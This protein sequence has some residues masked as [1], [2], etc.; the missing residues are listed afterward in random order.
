[1]QNLD[2]AI[3]ISIQCIRP[4]FLP[5]TL[6][7]W[8]LIDF[9]FWPPFI[10]DFSFILCV[11]WAVTKTMFSCLNSVKL[12]HKNGHHTGIS[13]LKFS[14]TDI[15]PC[16]M[17]HAVNLYFWH[18]AA[19]IQIK[20]V[21]FYSLFLALFSLLIFPIFPW[22]LELCLFMYLDERVFIT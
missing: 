11:S 3:S 12:Q 1:M 15:V 7:A 14:T 9:K 20:R 16:T 19:Y 4:V 2:S 10:S 21:T 18:S 13:P 6:D 17:Y 5:W 22:S 8:A